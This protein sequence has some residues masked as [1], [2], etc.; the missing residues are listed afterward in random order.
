MADRSRNF[1]FT[2]NQCKTDL[3]EDLYSNGK[4]EFILYGKEKAETTGHDHFQGCFKLKNAMTVSAVRKLCPGVHLEITQSVQASINYC[5]KDG[6]I[7][8]LGT[9]PQPPKKKLKTDEQVRV[10]LKDGKTISDV[11]DEVS[12]WHATLQMGLHGIKTAEKILQYQEPHRD[13][14]TVVK[15]FYGATGTGKTRKAA[16]EAGADAWWSGKNLKWWQGYDG[17]EKV[18]IDDFR[19]SFTCLDQSGDFCTFHELLRIL[20]RYPY[21]VEVSF[22]CLTSR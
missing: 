14:K 12:G 20:D 21:T 7:V 9:I 10:M 13:F 17:H 19:G 18:I 11:C 22:T 5:K 4:F 16:E 3:W 15:W 8:V 6:D 1:S 2:D